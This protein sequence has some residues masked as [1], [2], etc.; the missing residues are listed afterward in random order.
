[1][2]RQSEKQSIVWSTVM[3]FVLL[4]GVIPAVA[5][6]DTKKPAEQAAPATKKTPEKK[7]TAKSGSQKA[8]SSAA[9]KGQAPKYTSAETAAQA[10]ACFGEAPV[11]QSVRPDE[12]KPGETVTISGKGFGP[13]ACLRSL[14]FGPGYPAAFTFVSDT[15][16]TATVPKNRRKGMAMMTVT[17]ASGED[18]K[19]F[20]VK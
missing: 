11:V 8:K 20:L 7:A 14:S 15:Q 10:Q 12:G 18:S 6:E 1:M 9:A 2:R 16:I 5:A 3:G 17:T 4:G 13:A 19:A